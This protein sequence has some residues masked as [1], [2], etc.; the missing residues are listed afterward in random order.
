MHAAWSFQLA[1]R[2]RELASCWTSL[3]LMFER[4][5]AEI[6]GLPFDEVQ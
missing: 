5:V 6:L 2:S 1:A 3:H 4:E